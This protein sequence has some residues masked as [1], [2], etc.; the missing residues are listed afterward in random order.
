MA[1]ILIIQTTSDKLRAEILQDF[2]KEIDQLKNEYQRKEPTAF[3]TRN[4]VSE[5][6]KVDLSTVHNWTKSGKLKAYSI[7]TRVYFKRDEVEQS[8]IELKK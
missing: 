7:G 2:K 3:L 5:M 8:L 1:E 6:L 4:E